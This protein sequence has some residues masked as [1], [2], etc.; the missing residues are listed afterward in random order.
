MAIDF[1]IRIE[2]DLVFA[3]ASGYDE[4]LEEALDYNRAVLQACIEHDCSRIL[5]DERELEY[6]LDTV[7]TFELAT[8]AAR[9]VPSLTKIAIATG[10][11]NQADADFYET[12]AVNRGLSVKFFPDLDSAR[13]WLNKS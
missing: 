1:Q 8:Q 9:A 3:A 10:P 2:D 5:T 6:R 11:S 13:A 12:V 7:D 4:N